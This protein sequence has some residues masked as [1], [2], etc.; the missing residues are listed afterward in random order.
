M[1]PRA[2]ETNVRLLPLILLVIML[3]AVL[4]WS[5][6]WQNRLLDKITSIEASLQIQTNRFDK[7]NGLTNAVIEQRDIL[8]TALGHVLPVKMSPQWEQRLQSLEDQLKQKESWPTNENQSNKF[9]KELSALV[10]ELSPLAERNYFRQLSPLRWAAIAFNALHRKPKP[11]EGLLYLAEHLRATAS[12]K[13][14]DIY[15]DLGNMLLQRAREHE[16]EVEEGLI[17]QLIQQA[18]RYLTGGHSNGN[19][20]LPTDHNI[21][22]VYENLGLY[23]DHEE[24]SEKIKLLRDSL[25][26]QIPAREAKAQ[27]KSLRTRWNEVRKR[28]DHNEDNAS[29]HMI[30]ANMLLRDVMQAKLTATQQGI[31]TSKYNVLVIDIQKS[32]ASRESFVRRKY[33]EWALRKIMA[34]E[35]DFQKIAEEKEERTDERNQNK[36]FDRDL[37]HTPKDEGG[38]N[39]EEW[40][41]G[42]PKELLEEGKKQYD[43]IVGSMTPDQYKKVQNAMIW[44]LL[45]IDR[46]LLDLPVLNR[47]QR[48]FDRGWKRLSEQDQQTCVAIAASFV[49]KKTLQDVWNNQLE[50][51]PVEGGELWS[52]T[53]CE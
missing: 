39:F 24:R 12:A 23:I 22:E 48:E 10:A 11:N 35:H 31:D 52:E 6:W 21:Y 1:P 7:L 27:V 53:K 8:N 19:D 29:F 20:W 33:Q 47:Y 51:V 4:A 28:I 34:F 5:A 49:N 50:A 40:F 25:E 9:F 2:I 17:G 36:V 16:K 37:K 41:R 30:E 45:P 18:Q 32:I 15:P 44:H 42:M 43:S 14:A 26:S 38:V 3:A 46:A 13:P